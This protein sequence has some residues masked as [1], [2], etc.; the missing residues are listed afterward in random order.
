MTTTSSPVTI[1]RPLSV[2]LLRSWTVELSSLV[3][4]NPGKVTF[5][6]SSASSRVAGPVESS[7][8]LRSGV[9]VAVTIV[10][11]SI[12]RSPESKVFPDLRVDDDSF[13]RLRDLQL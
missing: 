5:V 8:V 10:S 9:V 11:I 3:P 7:V 4:V 6:L 12:G 13:G 1:E 2:A